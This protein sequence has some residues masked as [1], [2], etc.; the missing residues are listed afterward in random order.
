MMGRSCSGGIPLCSAATGVLAAAMLALGAASAQA[1]VTSS[2]VSTPADGTLLLANQ[3]TNPN[4]TVLVQGSAD[5]ASPGELVDIDCY[6][7]TSSAASYAGPGGTGI[8]LDQNL[9][10]SVQVPLDTFAGKTCLLLAV[11]HGSTPSPAGYNGPRVGFSQYYT[12]TVSSGPNQGKVEDFYF[13]DDT[14]LT[15]AGMNSVNSCGPYPTLLNADVS[16]ASTLFNCAGSF[17]D[18]S[19]Y[20]E[21]FGSE[22]TPDLTRSETLVD[23]KNAYGPNAAVSL[24]TGADQLSGLRGI[25]VSVKFA[26]TNANAQ[27]TE[28]DPLV[29]CTPHDVHDPTS[30]NCTSFVSTGVSIRRVTTF[31]SAGR[32]QKVTDSYLSTDAKSHTVDVLYENDLNVNT[33]GWELPGKPVFRPHNTGDMAAAPPAPVGS[34]YAIYKTG[35][36]PSL[37]N[38]LGA[39]TFTAPYSSARFDNTLWAN[40]SGGEQSVLFHYRRT[41]PAKGSTSLAWGYATEATLPAVR[42]D[43]DMLVRP[44]ISIASPRTGATEHAASVVV[45]GSARAGSGI[46]RVTVD[47]VMAIVSDGRFSATVP[48]RKGTNAIPAT[49]LTIAGESAHAAVT[50]TRSG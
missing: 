20:F 35:Y 32:V 18:S 38:P 45:R 13:D 43:A 37:S 24:F 25:S 28:I 9:S 6:E 1:A 5:S 17:F 27:V 14:L 34:V 16:A 42:R 2:T 44:A 48:L 10:F 40:Y 49:L 4:G 3:V 39:M 30:T 11:P 15:N 46:K 41:V 50:V 23:G 33:A 12:T 26:P 21:S 29:R 31:T 7:G 47:G 36:A 22:P 19:S 8:P